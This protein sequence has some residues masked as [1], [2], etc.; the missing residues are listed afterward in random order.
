M[1]Q[2]PQSPGAA[3]GSAEGMLAQILLQLEQGQAQIAQD[4]REGL[5]KLATGFKPDALKGSHAEVKRVWKFGTLFCSQWPRG[6]E[7]LG[8]ARGKTDDPAEAVEY[9]A[10]V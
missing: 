10:A 9:G 3:Q 7:G 8:W 6:Q 1:S 5:E 2:S 4:A